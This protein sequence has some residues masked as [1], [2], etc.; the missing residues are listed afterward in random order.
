ML[1]V[2]DDID[3]FSKETKK[4]E[5][6]FE[7]KRKER[8]FPAKWEV[9]GKSSS[10]FDFKGVTED[11]S[12]SG[13]A[14]YTSKLLPKGTRAHIKMALFSFGKPKVI[15]AVI[16]VRHSSISSNLY[17][18]G[19]QIIKITPQSEEFIKR[20]VAGKNPHI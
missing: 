1:E 10:G 6:T 16:E 2:V 9:E 17:R 3:I 7:N 15:D 12:I 4:T 5:P 13:L 18:C 14:M 8:R 20:Y 19:A 11:I